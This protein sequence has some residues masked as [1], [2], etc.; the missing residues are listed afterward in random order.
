MEEIQP[1]VFVVEPYEGE[2]LS[3]FLGRFRW[4]NGLTP[5]GLGREA[6]IGAVVA[7][8]EK[9]HLNPFPQAWELEKLAAVVQVSA[10][11]LSEML[12]PQGVEMKHQP[13]RLCGACYAE[14]LYHRLEWQF[15]Q[16]DRCE[17]HNLRLSS[18][19]PNCGAR[20]PI[21]ALWVDGW[22]QRCFLP[23]VE[24][25]KWQKAVVDR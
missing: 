9:F 17:K 23:F 24:M 4:E 7:R 18:E 8:W 6:G 2:S 1:W 19:C 15:K 22:C 11:R 14:V 10:E 5:S 25:A 21:P 13:I 16:T 20:F 12:P 3:H